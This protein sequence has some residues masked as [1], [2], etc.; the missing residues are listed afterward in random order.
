[1]KYEG[2][3][4]IELINDRGNCVT[5]FNWSHD[6]RQAVICYQDGFVLVGSVSGQRYWSNLYD[7]SNSV[8]TSATWTPNDA[9]IVLGLS[10]GSL[11]IVDENGTILSRHSVKDEPIQSLA[12]NS[13]KF[14]IHELI[15]A[16][17]HQTVLQTN[18]STSQ[19]GPNISSQIRLRLPN[20]NNNNF[21]NSSSSNSLIRSNEPSV[22]S[23]LK[24]KINNYNY[25]L[26]CS[27]KSNG[28]IYLLKS[29]DNSIDPVIIDTK[30]EGYFKN[31]F[32]LVSV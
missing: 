7:L 8:I 9:Q 4:S 1:M 17:K 28:L 5:D 12:Y 25:V 27:F 22:N 21:L 30:L 32:C 23:K 16:N 18:E 20:A 15:E 6:G 10:N 11:M 2:R 14:F 26:A 24:N 3:W 13:P 19:H 31:K 29:Y